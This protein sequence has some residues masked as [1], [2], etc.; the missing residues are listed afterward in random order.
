MNQLETCKPYLFRALGDREGLPDGPAYCFEV[1]VNGKT[2]YHLALRNLD[3]EDL[4]K[5][6]YPDKGYD[7]VKQYMTVV[8]LTDEQIASASSNFGKWAGG[9]FV[10]LSVPLDNI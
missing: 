10:R 5:R 7:I 4:M 1:V 9:E 6:E 8:A 3:G 2:T